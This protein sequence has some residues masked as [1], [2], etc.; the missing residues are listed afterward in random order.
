MVC[1]AFHTDGFALVPDVL[2]AADCDS[3]ALPT[4]PQGASGGSRCLLS[5]RWCVS[6]VCRVREHPVLK[7]T[8]PARHAAVQC[9]YFEKSASR[10][11]LVPIHQDLSIPVAA[12]VNSAKLSG[13]STKEETTYVHAP[14]E[15]LQDLI[16]LRLHIDPCTMNDGPLRVVPASHDKGILAPQAAAL[17]R[18]SGGEVVCEASQGAALVMRPL[19]LH[20]SSK[21]QGTSR[22]RVLHFLFGPRSL[23]Y[24]LQWQHAI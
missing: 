15:V 2:K 21:T 8:I 3:L 16:A 23:P 20:A 6:L 5:E 1:A 10:N 4:L 14:V 18:R 7:R 12:R 11:W 22:R 24:G 13:W 19:L 17:A 9:T